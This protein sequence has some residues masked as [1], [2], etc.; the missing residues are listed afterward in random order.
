VTS[1]ATSTTAAAPVDPDALRAALQAALR[2]HFAD[3]ALSIATLER[4]PSE[5]RSSF[6][7]EDLDVALADGRRLELLFKDASPG[8][9]SGEA[10]LVKPGFLRDPGREIYVYREVLPS[11]GVS[12]PVCFGVDVDEAAGRYWIFLEKV[13]GVELYQVGPVETWEHAARWL[14]RLH[15]RFAPRAGALATQGRLIVQNPALWRGWIERACAFAPRRGA[16]DVQVRRLARLAEH[17]GVVI[18]R[19]TAE[20]PTFLHGEFYASNVL[21]EELG[22]RV[23]VKPVDWEMAAV[24]PGALELAALVSGKW[25]ELPRRRL[26]SAYCD[27]LAGFDAGVARGVAASIDYARLHLAVQW[28]GWSEHWVP[29]PQHAHDWLGEAVELADAL[30][31]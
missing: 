18:D 27:A 25:A 8:A 26:V 19:L 14:A 6:V 9:M 16:S 30:G 28:L 29:P 10:A 22:D 24:G 21:V 20:P 1:G 31:L 5:Y 17:Y 15:G 2:Q 13:K 4:R 23:D 3:P 11:A 7:I 12:A